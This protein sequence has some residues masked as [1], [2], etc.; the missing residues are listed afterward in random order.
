MQIFFSYFFVIY[1]IY[2]FFTPLQAA[3]SYMQVNNFSEEALGQKS[4][5]CIMQ[6]L[7][8]PKEAKINKIEGV[9]KIMIS[10]KNNQIHKFQI[11]QSSG[12][13]IFD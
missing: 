9:A 5:G 3:D 1:V 7:L 12:Y 2:Q 10:L 8:Y 6:H 11:I 13:K 4:R